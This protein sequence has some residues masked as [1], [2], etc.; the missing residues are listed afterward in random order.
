MSRVDIRTLP[1]FSPLVHDYAHEFSRLSGYF[2]R[3][4]RADEEYTKLAELCD[5]RDYH[6]AELRDALLTQQDGWDGTPVARQRIEELCTARG[7][8][9]CTG[10]QTGLF[11]GPLFT[12]YKAL[13]AITVAARLERMLRRHVVPVFWMA[14]EDHDLPEADHV[15]LADRDGR[16]IRVRHTTWGSPGGFMPANLRLGPAIQDIVEQLRQAMPRTEFSEGLLDALAGTYAPNRTLAE[17][18]A[19]WLTF[20]LGET[21]LVLVDGSDPNLK[22]LAA[23]ILRREIDE[24]PRTSAAVLKVSQVLRSGGYPAQIEARPDGVNCFLLQGGRRSLARDATGFRLRD[25]GEV[26]TPAAL[27]QIAEEAPE[28]LSPNVALRPVVQDTLFPT[29]A[30]VAGP[31]ELAYFAQLRPVYDIY[32]VPMPVIV[33]RAT[34]S[35]VEPRIAQLLRRFGVGLSDLTHEPEQLASRILRTQLPPDLGATLARAREGVDEIFRQVGEAVAAV[36]ST[37]RAT[38]GQTSGHIK[39]HLDQLE[40]KAVQALKRREADTGQQLQRL[41]DALMPGGRLQE[42]VYPVLPYLAKYGVGLIRWLRE[43]IDGPGWEHQLATI[44]GDARPGTESSTS[45]SQES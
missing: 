1:G 32:D 7:L 27:H 19:R 28:R 44:P 6:R 35:L 34:I 39:G 13:T 33:P 5:T 42:R 11:G 23:G 31:G 41:R 45:A 25:T 30:Y 12:L 4:P 37:L 43:K 9:V 16:L 17:A 21:G 40:R 2:A 15:W 38:A 29:L 10:Q 24:A 20:L 8:A 18:F 36:D 22:R 3:N 26:F 14:S